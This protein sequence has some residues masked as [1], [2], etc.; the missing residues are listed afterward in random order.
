MGIG[1]SRRRRTLR[2]GLGAL[3]VGVVLAVFGL[4]AP[5][6]AEEAGPPEI[7]TVSGCE[8]G[9][10]TDLEAPSGTGGDEVVE[11]LCR[12]DVVLSSLLVSIACGAGGMHLTVTNDG[13]TDQDTEVWN[14][15]RLLQGLVV[16]VKSAVDVLVPMAEGEQYAI[17]VTA[18]GVLVGSRDCEHA[19]PSILTP[20]VSTTP[21]VAATAAAPETV[22]VR[23]PVEV[24][25]L[26]IVRGAPTLARTGNETDTLTLVGLSLVLLGIGAIVLGRGHAREA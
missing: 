24:Q 12:E 8:T 18:V 13:D 20:T 5:A 2:L 10:A 9:T 19:L 16:P 22:A 14:N 6:G 7:S 26:Q 25:G 23:R 1:Q 4:A 3:S 11:P 17:D 21:V 15:G